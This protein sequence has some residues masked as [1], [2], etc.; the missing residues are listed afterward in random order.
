MG[1]LV[2][3][4][5]SRWRDF[6]MGRMRARRTPHKTPEM[7]A[8]YREREGLDGVQAALETFDKHRDPA[9]PR[10]NELEKRIALAWL[11]LRNAERNGDWRRADQLQF[12]TIPR[13]EMEAERA[14]VRVISGQPVLDPVQQQFQKKPPSP[15]LKN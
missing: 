2:G 13:L 1:R 6:R 5:S 7:F 4:I 8:E 14:A 10:R 3:F 12:G 15:T 11:A 9:L